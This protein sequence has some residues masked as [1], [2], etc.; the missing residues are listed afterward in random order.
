MSREFETPQIAESKPDENITDF[1]L[2]RRTKY[3]DIPL[4]ERQLT[5]GTWSPM[6]APEFITLVKRL[7]QGLINEGVKPGDRVAIM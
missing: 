4:W 5:P 7:A 6:Y 1:L 2:L 3:A